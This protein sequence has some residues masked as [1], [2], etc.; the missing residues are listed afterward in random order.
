MAV[1]N[2]TF[3]AVFLLT[4]VQLLI[5]I[6]H[7]GVSSIGRATSSSAASVIYDRSYFFWGMPDKNVFGARIALFGFLYILMALVSNNKFP[8]YRGTIVLLCA[9]LSNSR[10]P[11]VA[12]FIGIVF[13]VFRR[14]RL[15]GKIVLAIVISGITPFFLFSLLRFDSLTSPSDGMGIRIIYWSTFFSHFKTL[16]MLGSGFM[17]AQPF[18]TKYSPIY[19]GEPHLH[20]LFLNTYL[21]F[22]V[23]GL[24]FYVLFLLFF[25][26]Y[27]KNRFPVSS[28][29]YW[30]AA[31]L[32]LIAIMLTL[33]NGYESDTVIYLLVI[34]LIGRDNVRCSK[35]KFRVNS[36]PLR[37]SEKTI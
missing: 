35:T 29:W 11:M 21:D 2:N 18:L 36:V 34:F 37:L 15:P 19:L 6:A 32:P 30:T 12:L 3:H 23:P 7:A 31:F 24:F 4:I 14:S 16:S 17:S 27:C 26:R 22:G 20:N 8:M 25:Y 28:S 33:S 13:I 9:F 1:L 10:T 5:Y